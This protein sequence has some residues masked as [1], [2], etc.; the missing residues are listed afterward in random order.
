M[1]ISPW[2]EDDAEE[3]EGARW[4]AA[5]VPRQRKKV[6]HRGG[7][8]VVGSGSLSWPET[9]ARLP[10]RTRRAVDERVKKLRRLGGR[11]ED[12]EVVE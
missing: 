1:E 6:D 12:E 11:E 7:C 10:D 8:G 9:C 2:S 3:E 5:C 4:A